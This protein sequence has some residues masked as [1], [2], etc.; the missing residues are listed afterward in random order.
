MQL[1]QQL[2]LQGYSYYALLAA[3][4]LKEEVW[5]LPLRYS[6]IAPICNALYVDLCPPCSRLSPESRDRCLALVLGEGGTHT[7]N[8][9]N[10]RADLRFVQ[11]QI[12]WGRAA[13][14]FCHVYSV[15]ACLESPWHADIVGLW[16]VVTEL[17][18]CLFF[19]LK[20]VAA[21]VYLVHVLYWL[22]FYW[23][24]CGAGSAITLYTKSSI[25]R[26]K[27]WWYKLCK[28]SEATYLSSWLLVTGLVVYEGAAADWNVCEWW[29]VGITCDS[30]N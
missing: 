11:R 8:N 28:S 16:R 9:I 14:W 1:E 4:A 2:S 3:Q 26:S 10:L 23:V 29:Q 27:R 17:N 13:V 21:T 6:I 20:S 18:V 22:N 19:L 24:I 30:H 15:G 5:F 12:T 25:Y 7:Q